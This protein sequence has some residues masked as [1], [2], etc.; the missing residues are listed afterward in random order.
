[1][2][3]HD[4][5]QSRKFL[6]TTAVLVALCG[7]G[8]LLAA[9]SAQPAGMVSG[10]VGSPAGPV[11]GA[12]V[13][14]RATENLT[15]TTAN[16]SFTLI[17]LQEGEPIEVAAWAAGYY[18]ASTSVTPT[19]SGITLTLRPYHTTDHP[20]YTWA[21]PI[22]GTSSTACGGCHPMIFPQWAGNAHGSAVG[23]DRFF[24]MYNGTDVMGGGAVEPGY[25]LDFPGTAGVCAECHAP[26]AGVDGYLTT[27]MNAV[28]DVITAGIH[29]DYCHK[30]GGVYLDPATQT[31]YPNA[32]G[33]R[34]QRVLRPPPGDNIF[35]GPYDDIHDPDTYLPAIS[36][37]RFCAPCHQFS[38]W[39]TP[40]YESYEEWL[41]SPYAAEGITCQDCHMVPN[42]DSYFARPEVGG[43]AHPPES[44]PSHLQLGARD[45]TFLQTTAAL[46]LTASPHLDR[47]AVTVTLTNTGAGHHIPTDYPGRQ[48]LLLV[49]AENELGETLP[50]VSGP[51]VPGWGGAQAGNPGKAYAK[52]LQDVQSGAWP[53]VSYWRQTSILTDTR[54]PALGSDRSAYTFLSPSGGG[55]IRLHAQLILRHLFQPLAGAK[56]WPDG[57][58]TLAQV[59]LELALPPHL[60]LFLPIVKQ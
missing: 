6:V 44:I 9:A 57:D 58:L 37:S 26:G 45:E 53:V 51:A 29:C 60:D 31:V 33:T 27:G 28:R 11:A 49:T 8:V 24:S 39:G 46:T 38:M 17:G 21:S 15:F 2:H 18:I 10:R 35:F 40:I 52:I 19:I 12:R 48:L 54:I 47:L 23:S 56:G 5:P 1:M 43:L 20:D 34:S 32:P 16:G 25:L 30:I 3:R 7:L 22:T 13:R 42:G 50:L 4:L 36:E 14:V 41:A 59:E 55:P